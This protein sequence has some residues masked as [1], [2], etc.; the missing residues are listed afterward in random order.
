MA[1]APVPCQFPDRL[2]FEHLES[3]AR[4]EASRTEISQA[5]RK[6]KQN[7]APA[8]FKRNICDAK[9][10]LGEMATK[11][12][13]TP[14]ISRIPATKQRVFDQKLTSRSPTIHAS[15]LSFS[16]FGRDIRTSGQGK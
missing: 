9:V 12:T 13:E 8:T 5:R 16:Q 10:T 2:M 6:L 7:R 1:R 14:R 15:M 3:Q 4:I 11:G